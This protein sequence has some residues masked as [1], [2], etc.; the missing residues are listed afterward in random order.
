MSAIGG[1]TITTSFSYDANGNQTAGLGRSITWT[2]YNKPASITQGARTLSFLDDPN[3]QRFQ[4]VTPQGTTLYF[5]SFGAHAEFM[6]GSGQWNEYLKVGNVL[7]GVRFLTLATETVTLRYFHTDHLGSI[8]VITDGNGAVSE[9]LS[10]DAWGKRR[11]PNGADDPSGSITSATTRGFTGQEELAVTGLVHLNGRV[12]DSLTGRMMSAD[13]TVPDALNP[14]AWNRYSYVGN[15]PLTFTDPTGYSWLSS[16]FSSIGNFFKSIFSNSIVRAIVQIAIAAILTPVGLTGAALA[17]GAALAAAAST[18][19][20]TGLAGGKLGQILKAAVIA[21][22]TAFAFTEVGN[23][24]VTPANAAP[25]IAA[26]NYAANIAGHAAIGCVSAVA[27]GGKCG[28]GA[29]SG[30]A[31]AAAAPLVGDI[32]QNAPDK[33]T[34]TIEGSALSGVVGGLASVAGG[35]KFENGAVTGAFGYLFNQAA[36]SG[37]DPNDRH[38]LGVDAA[39]ADYQ[40]R[41]YEIIT[42]APVAV[43]VAGFPTPRFYDFLVRDPVAG[44]TLGIEVK[45]TLYDTIRLNADQVAKDVAVVGGGGTVRTIVGLSI[46]GVG[47][48]TYCFACSV[49][50]FR[51]TALYGALRSAG[52]PF[53]HGGRPGEIRP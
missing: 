14:Q 45:T 30:A 35:G 46:N 6:P 13:P 22:A 24:T 27:S 16:F 52:V 40:A 34:Q 11:F 12:Y 3:H 21:G 20:V 32:V 33:F 17:V 42:S 9:R 15:D 19:I 8:A 50:D 44:V 25:E 38:Q 37:T 41:G 28:P 5:D 51:S 2:S 23:L 48:Q 1:G 49:V 36:H 26:S 43:D 39:I 18:A 31:G 53:G 10:Y 4:Q 47:Y 7:V 29:L